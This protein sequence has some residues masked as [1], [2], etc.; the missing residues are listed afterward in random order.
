MKE[1]DIKTEATYLLGCGLRNYT[2]PG[3]FLPGPS[4]ASCSPCG[5]A[6]KIRRRWKKKCAESSGE[7]RRTTG[8]QR[9]GSGAVVGASKLGASILGLSVKVGQNQN[10]CGWLV[11]M[12]TRNEIS[13]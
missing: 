3:G 2:R 4:A 1:K 5:R 7:R 13:I 6:T 10:Q 8:G 9:S 12:T 11:V